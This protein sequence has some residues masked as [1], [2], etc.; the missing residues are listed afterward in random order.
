VYGIRTHRHLKE[1]LHAFLMA[2]NLNALQS[3]HAITPWD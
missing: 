3:I 1:H 2:K